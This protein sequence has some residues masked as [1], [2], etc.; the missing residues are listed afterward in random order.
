MIQAILLNTFLCLVIVWLLILI[1][2][3]YCYIRFSLR[4]GKQEE[5]AGSDKTVQSQDTEPKPVDAHTLVGKSKGL[6][7]LDFPRAPSISSAE[8]REEKSNTFVPQEAENPDDEPTISEEDNEMDVAYTTDEV[9]EDEVVREELLLDV[10]PQPEVSPSAILARDL[11]RMARWSKSDEELNE[12]DEAEVQASFSKIQGSDL[13][14]KY[15][16]NLLAEEAKHSRLLSL[17]R[18]AE[19][20]QR[21]EDVTIDGTLSSMDASEARPLDYYL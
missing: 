21:Q 18:K 4:W 10:S 2:Y 17:V 8:T 19:E 20:E 12:E 11:V 3:S 5:Q 14:A 15:K 1:Y 9:D 7:S 6:S 16:E 13:M